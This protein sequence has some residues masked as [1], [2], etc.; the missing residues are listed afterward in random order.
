MGWFS[1]SEKTPS[2]DAP[3][4]SNDGGF[5]APDRNQRAHCWEARDVYFACLDRNNILDSV[6]EANKAA[7]LC[8]KENVGFEKNCASS[9]VSLVCC[10]N[11]L[12]G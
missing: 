11:G 6:K 3:K 10:G 2:V 5:I 1:S 9:W 4:P 7:T 12:H 8:G